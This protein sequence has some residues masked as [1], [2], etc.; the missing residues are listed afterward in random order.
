[1]IIGGR[2]TEAAPEMRT[3]RGVGPQKSGG[4]PPKLGGW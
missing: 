2:G 1:M 4:Q 3:G